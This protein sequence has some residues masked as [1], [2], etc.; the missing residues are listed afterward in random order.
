VTTAVGSLRPQPVQ[1]AE[2]WAAENVPIDL[3]ISTQVVDTVSSADSGPLG[4]MGRYLA[5]VGEFLS[6]PWQRKLPWRAH[7]LS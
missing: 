1:A 5:L 7:R 3:P 4:L 6:S 2:W